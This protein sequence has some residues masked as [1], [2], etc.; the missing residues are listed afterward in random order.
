MSLNIPKANSQHV[1]LSGVVIL[2]LLAA[3]AAYLPL[4]DNGFINLD[5]GIY[6]TFNKHVQLG[7][8]LDN[9]KWAF[10]FADKPGT[11]WHPATWLSL[12]LDHDLF[13][14]NP[15]GYHGINLLLHTANALLI[16]AILQIITRSTLASA[17]CAAI[18][19]LH[20]VNVEAVAWAVERKTVL[21]T[22]FGL[23]CVLSYMK[24]VRQPS[25]ARYLVVFLLLAL[26][27]MAKSMLVTLPCALLLLDYWPLGRFRAFSPSIMPVDR[28]VPHQYSISFLVLE[29]IP[30]L[31]L[32]AS[33]FFITLYSLRNAAE[34][35][36]PVFAVRI[37]NALV[38]YAFYLKVLLWPSELAVY[39]PPRMS[40]YPSWQVIV[41]V[42]VLVMMT[43]IAIR[44]IRSRPWWFVG[45]FWYAGTLFTTSGL[46]RSGLWPERAD[47][48]I[49]LPCFGLLLI[50]ACEAGRLVQGGRALRFTT[51]LFSTALITLLAVAT[52]Q[53]VRYW[54]DDASLFEHT[55]Q[56]TS[57]NVHARHLLGKYYFTQ[58]DY[59]KAFN[60]FAAE[61]AVDPKNPDYDVFM[62]Y[63]AYLNGNYG[64]ARESLER[65]LV[66][67]PDNL[68]ALYLLGQL[69]EKTGNIGQ[70]RE[71]YS[72]GLASNALDMYSMKPLLEERLKVLDGSTH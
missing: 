26:G 55:V 67:T 29:K 32:S 71:Y 59:L 60:Q 35:I 51:I 72:K 4:W 23:L 5:D 39:Y 58:G 44:T 17:V 70:A 38:S 14:L 21:C 52:H 16:F 8:T 7:L 10:S 15:A 31:L 56:V 12:M 20:P 64:F 65:V 1:K 50:L 19:L 25:I 48:F 62:G 54:K 34:P 49:Y 63:L 42:A 33:S 11:Y 69:F 47:R 9:L 45:F 24:Y 68:D 22:F 37:E 13:G 40:H 6:I 27:L 30:L 43:F 18:F 53:Q 3:A 66:S 28:V 2:M 61:K 46:M 36:F 57:N 41:A